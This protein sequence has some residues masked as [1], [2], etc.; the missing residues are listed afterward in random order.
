MMV[1]DPYRKLEIGSG[2]GFLSNL[3]VLNPVH[4]SRIAPF[5]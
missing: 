2:R 5:Q 4:D 3:R 1:M